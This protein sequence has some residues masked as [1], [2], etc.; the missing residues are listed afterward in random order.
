MIVLHRPVELAAVWSRKYFQIQ[1][2]HRPVGST[3]RRNTLFL[4]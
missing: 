1:W 4:L 3:G 2:Q